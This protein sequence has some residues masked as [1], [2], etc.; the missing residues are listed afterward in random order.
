MHPTMCR[1]SR[2]LRSPRRQLRFLRRRRRCARAAPARRSALPRRSGPATTPATTC[3]PTSAATPQPSAD[4]N[5]LHRTGILPDD[6]A[7]DHVHIRCLHTEQSNRISAVVFVDVSPAT[8]GAPTVA[9]ALGGADQS[10]RSPRA[11]TAP[12]AMRPS[13]LRG[14]LERLLV[15]MSL[16]RL[17]L[18]IIQLQA[19]SPIWPANVFVI[20]DD[21]ML[22]VDTYSAELTIAQPREI[23]LY[24]KAFSL[25]Q[26]AASYGAPEREILV[27]AL[28]TT[29]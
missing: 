12:T 25:L 3:P 10:N 22:M 26:S 14:Q 21:R 13:I 28:A 8:V 20:F 24:A 11:T 29:P 5:S 7:D 16:P 18:A 17:S 6:P 19:A 15:A 1:S 2:R 23:S 9:S 4:R 27:R